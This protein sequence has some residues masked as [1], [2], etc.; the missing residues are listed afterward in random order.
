MKNL[1]QIDSGTLNESFLAHVKESNTLEIQK[2]G[3]HLFE[4]AELAGLFAAKV[5]LYDVGQGE[6]CA[7]I[8]AKCKVSHNI[9]LT[10][11]ICIER[12]KEQVVSSN[13]RLSILFLNACA[14]CR[15]LVGKDS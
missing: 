13:K 10:D 11:C 3:M 12:Q 7:Q 5:G 15:N 2:L 9:G 8:F 4:A 6:L 1:L 14:S